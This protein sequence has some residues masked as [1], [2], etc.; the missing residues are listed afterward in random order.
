MND[1]NLYLKEFLQVKFVLIITRETIALYV[2]L[3][4]EEIKNPNIINEK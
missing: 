2:E 3:N 4:N 1:S